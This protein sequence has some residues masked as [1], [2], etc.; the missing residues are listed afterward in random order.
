MEHTIAERHRLTHCCR[1]ADVGEE[2]GAPG[3][4]AVHPDRLVAEFAQTVHGMPSDE[5]VAASD[6]DFHAEGLDRPI[7]EPFQRR[8]YFPLTT[9]FM[10][11]NFSSN[12]SE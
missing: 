7:H 10:R 1:V 9:M 11:P 4:D 5:P 12:T 3:V 8:R 6:E 2:L